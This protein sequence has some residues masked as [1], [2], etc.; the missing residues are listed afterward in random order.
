MDFNQWFKVVLSYR[1]HSFVNMP[2]SEKMATVADMSKGTAL[3][4]Q[5]SRN[6]QLAP[7]AKAALFSLKSIMEEI[8]GNEGKDARAHVKELITYCARI[9]ASINIIKRK[10]NGEDR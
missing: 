1:D 8:E 7:E 3:L 6:S 9:K 2:L 5:Y 10:E 4:N